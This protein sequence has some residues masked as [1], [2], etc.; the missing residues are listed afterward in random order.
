[1]QAHAGQLEQE[2]TTKTQALRATNQELAL[3]ESY[4]RALV[5]AAPVGIAQFD[6]QGQCCYLNAVGCTLT[7]CTEETAR[8]RHFLAFV[9]PDDR[10]YVEFMWQ[11]NIAERKINWLEFRLQDSDIWV[12]AHWINL[13]EPAGPPLSGSIVILTDITEQRSKD[14]QIWTQANYD[15]LTELPNRNLFWER[16]DQSLR[17][18]KRG[19][20]QVGLLWI[21]LDGFKAIND[22]LGHAA[23]DELLQQVAS[24]LNSRTLDS[25]TV[26]R[27]GGDEFTVI[28]PDIADQDAAAQVAEDLTARL[29]EPFPLASGTGLISASIGVALYPPH[30]ESAEMLFKYADM[31]M[32]VAKNAGKNQVFVWQP[33]A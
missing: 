21:D 31:A 5:G 17:R 7:A 10:D 4:L 27:M 26:A 20:Q 25:D 9:H 22:Q 16:L 15:A 29:A 19:D 18:A 2:V 12:S 14:E 24:R 11:T 33:P 1:L 23:G 3:K 13:M 32:Y 6:A 8:G 28:L 30:A